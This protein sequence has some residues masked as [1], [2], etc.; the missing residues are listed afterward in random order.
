MT[1]LSR[2]EDGSASET[3]LAP[4]YQYVGDSRSGERRTDNSGNSFWTF[5][6]QYMFMS[7]M[8]GMFNRPVYQSDYNTYSNYR[9][10]NRPYYGENNQY[11]TNGTIIT[12]THKIFFARKM[13]KQKMAKRSF[14]KKVEQRIG[15]Y[16]S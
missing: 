11:G 15:R 5:Y 10:N 1:L 14:R 4:A 16:V 2:T 7:H 8:F 13:A 3:P 9:K 12:Q 6:G